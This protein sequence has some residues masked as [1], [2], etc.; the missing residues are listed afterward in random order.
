MVP[1]PRSD[2]V[3]ISRWNLLTFR[4]KEGFPEVKPYFTEHEQEKMFDEFLKNFHKEERK[5][6]EARQEAL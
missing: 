1:R 6:R 2:K 4:H 5:I 3:D